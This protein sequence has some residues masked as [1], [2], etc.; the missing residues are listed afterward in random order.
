MLN[1][2]YKS[3]TANHVLHVIDI[4]DITVETK[5]LL[6]K[7]LIAICEGDSDTEL[8]LV[9]K[10][11]M[12]FL[13][14]KKEDTQMG[15]VAEFLVHLYLNQLKFK[16]EF[17]FFNLEENS[18]KK[19]FDGLFSKDSEIYLV[20]SK[21]GSILSKDISHKNKIISAY[22]DL[23]KYVSGKSKK[24]NNNPWKN[25]YNHACH[26]DVATEKSIRK[27]YSS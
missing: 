6:D 24:G 14:S 12:S 8:P 4:K 17:L 13:E 9:K 10:R 25:A 7:H 26:L 18:I 1:A 23:E 5:K 21:S 2:Q 20:E 3:I 22:S 16:Q 11:L 15:A 19:G 27:K